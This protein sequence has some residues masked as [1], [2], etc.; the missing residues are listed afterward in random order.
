MATL[1]ALLLA[2]R[3]LTICQRSIPLSAHAAQS[4]SSSIPIPPSSP[5][6]TALTARRR[7]AVKRSRSSNRDPPRLPI[8]VGNQV[9]LVSACPLTSRDC[10]QLL[11]R[12]LFDL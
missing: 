8:R 5:S 10:N 7:P 9:G 3:K 6:V 11:R 4:N 2:E 1:N 12:P